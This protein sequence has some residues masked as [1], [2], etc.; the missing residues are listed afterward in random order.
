VLG[1]QQF[2]SNHRSGGCVPVTLPGRDSFL[3]RHDEWVSRLLGWQHQRTNRRSK[4]VHIFL[5]FSRL[6]S[7][8]RR[9]DGRPRVCWGLNNS[10]QTASPSGAFSSVAEG[11]YHTCGIRTNRTVACWGLGTN[12]ETAPTGTFSSISAGFL[13]SCGVRTDGALVCWGS[14]PGSSPTGTFS[15]VS[16]GQYFACAIRTGGSV[17]CWEGKVTPPVGA[18]KSVS[19]GDLHACGIKTDG[20]IACWGDTGYDKTLAPAGTFMPCGCVN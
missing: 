11:Y 9:E 20:T 15:S 2:R 7:H 14:K 10:G 1:Q 17:V 5:R 16:A 6:P 19:V 12:G 3:R 13:Y 4:W 8:V 18:F